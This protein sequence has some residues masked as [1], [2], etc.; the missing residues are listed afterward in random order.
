M[1]TRNIIIFILLFSP[2]FFL[3]NSYSYHVL[4]GA[5]EDTFIFINLPN[6]QV[7]F[8]ID[9]GTLGGSSGLPLIEAACDEWDKV[10]NV[11]SFCG[12]ITQIEEDITAS[13]FGEIVSSVDGIND[14]IFDEVGNIPPLLGFPTG[15]LG[16]GVTTSDA[17]TGEILDIRIVINGSVTS[18]A[19]ADLLST[20]IHEMGHTWG[21]AHN[22]IGGIN[23]TNSV[24]GFDRI[25]PSAIPTMYPFAIPEDDRFGRTLEADDYAAALLLYGP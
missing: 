5:F 18:S 11:G 4:N 12:T 21:L 16:L 20:V 25:S 1:Q 22:S 10:P 8:R 19:C 13:N 17:S 24:P 7:D 3:K 23:M 15:V 14:I 9:G 6:L 2:F